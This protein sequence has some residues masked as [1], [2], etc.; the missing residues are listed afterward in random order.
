MFSIRQRIHSQVR[1][2][3]NRSF[4]SLSV[5][6]SNPPFLRPSPPSLP[7]KEQ[8]EFERLLKQQQA[9]FSSPTQDTA[10]ELHP[11]L[12]A[13][14]PPEFEGDVNPQTGEVG[15]PKRDPLKWEREWAYG[16]RATDF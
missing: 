3:Y 15:G 16:G 10:T 1:S 12:R 14:P 2:T 7:P 9:P 4:S 5:I 11:D 13:K 8:A 6:R